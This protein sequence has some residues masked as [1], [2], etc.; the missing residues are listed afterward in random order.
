M[1][2]CGK[3]YEGEG[4]V[5]FQGIGDADYAAFRDDGVRGDCLLDGTCEVSIIVFH[6]KWK[7]GLSY[8]Y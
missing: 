7:I 1:L 8:Q 6:S 4:E 2:R 5:A 3:C